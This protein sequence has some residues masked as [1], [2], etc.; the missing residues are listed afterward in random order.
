M[1]R[2]DFGPIRQIFARSVCGVFGSEATAC[3]W[4]P[5]SDPSSNIPENCR[6]PR[7]VTSKKYMRTDVGR[8]SY[9]LYGQIHALTRLRVFSL[10]A[11][12]TTVQTFRVYVVIGFRDTIRL[13]AHLP[14]Q[15]FWDSG[16][17]HV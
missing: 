7:G 10:I 9:E 2:Q 13:H 6:V 3:G 4:L 8:P 5:V 15:P 1:P 16:H 12:E 14:H 11:A 17:P